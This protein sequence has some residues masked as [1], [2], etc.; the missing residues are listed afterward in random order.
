MIISSEE[1]VKIYF[2]NVRMLE[3]Y[4]SHIFRRSD[5]MKISELRSTAFI[6]LLAW[7]NKKMSSFKKIS[8][9]QWVVLVVVLSVL[10]FYIFN[11]MEKEDTIDTAPVESTE[12]KVAVITTSMGDIEIELFLKE[13]PI[14]AQNFQKLIKEGFYNGTR[15]HRVI[16]NFMVQ[17]G[18]P[19]SKDLDAIDSWGMGGP[20][21]AIEDEFIEGLSN[22]RGTISMANSGP[23]SGGSQF[24]INL[25]DNI[26]LDW[27]KGD[28]RSKHPVFGK[29]VSGIE[30][31]DKIGE[32]ATE[33]SDRP[34]ED[35]MIE[36]IIIK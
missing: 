23:Q 28:S 15:F 32:V 2:H 3:L 35:V 34:V 1:H 31:L 36:K 12:N 6:P 16:G 5:G 9:I 30:V 24:F 20:G 7:N 33:G 14:T 26:N 10:A 4:A 13:S 29:V 8:I 22:V 17:G 21:Y 25:V 11:P 18:D 27:D 19:N